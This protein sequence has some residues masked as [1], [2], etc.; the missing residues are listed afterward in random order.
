M[1]KARIYAK[2]IAENDHTEKNKAFCESILAQLNKETSAFFELP[3][4][5]QALLLVEDAVHTFRN[6]RYFL[7][8]RESEVAQ[9]I[10]RMNRAAQRLK[11]LDIQYL[12]A[13]ML[14]GE[15]GTGKTSFGRYL[16]FKLR[17]PFLYVNPVSYTHLRY[18][19]RSMECL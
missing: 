14:Y 8:P 10:E 3:N 18:F 9:E 16:S 2:I 19:I 15:S 13:T 11:E 5:L 4:K 1:K 6:D 7:T 12:N 17:L